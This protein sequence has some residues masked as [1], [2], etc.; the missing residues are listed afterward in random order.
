MMLL[1]TLHEVQERLNRNREPEIKM[2]VTKYLFKEIQASKLDYRVVDRT[3]T[4][5][6]TIFICRKEKING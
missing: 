2:T 6:R 3:C 4:G 1:N 5:H